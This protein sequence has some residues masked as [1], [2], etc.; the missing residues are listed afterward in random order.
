MPKTILSRFVDSA[1]KNV[2]ELNEQIKDAGEKATGI[3]VK[4]TLIDKT[5]DLVTPEEKKP[6]EKKESSSIIQK[7]RVQSSESKTEDKG[8]AK[9]SKEEKKP[10][11]KKGLINKLR[12][13]LSGK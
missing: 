9:K 10:E 4:K 2:D 12:D 8:K 6:E 1:K 5:K 7:R 13:K 11:E 3:R